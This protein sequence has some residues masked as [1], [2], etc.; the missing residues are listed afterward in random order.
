MNAAGGLLLKGDQ[1]QPH[2]SGRAV[3]PAYLSKLGVLY[4]HISSQSEVDEL[5]KARDY[6]N[7]DEI[8]VSP[9]KM[10][11]IYE[12]KVKSFFH[13]HL[14]EDE[15]IRYILDGA[16]YFDVRSEGDDW[17]RIWLEKGDLI[18]LPSGIYH[19]F[20]TDEQNYTKAMRLFKDE[21]KWTPLNRGEE[22]DEN[23]FR[24][25]YLKLRQGLAA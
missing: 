4:H 18:I 23:Q 5:A 15:E 12:E 20:T 3:D 19:R 17:V 13:E 16:G 2:D 11:D 10:G 1:R 21:P 9:E 8:T 14:H 6:K 24:Q 25:E 7:R 22:T